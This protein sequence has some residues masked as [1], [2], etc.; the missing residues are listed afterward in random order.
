M[1]VGE[2]NFESAIWKDRTCMG[3]IGSKLKCTKIYTVDR[4]SYLSGGALVRLP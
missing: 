3:G 2:V 4:D 1:V